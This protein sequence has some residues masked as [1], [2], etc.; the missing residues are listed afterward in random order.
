MILEPRVLDQ[1]YRYWRKE[2]RVR[3]TWESP[4]RLDDFITY[5]KQYRH[6]SNQ[7]FEDWLFEQGFTVVQKNKTRYLEFSGDERRLTFLLLKYGGR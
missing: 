1:F 6:G 7:L 5:Q 2:R 4:S 3:S